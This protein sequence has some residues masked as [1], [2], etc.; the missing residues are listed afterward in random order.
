MRAAVQ[1]SVVMQYVIA[2]GG[3]GMMTDAD[4][5]FVENHILGQFGFL[6]G[7]AQ[8]IYLGD[9]SEA[10]IANRSG[11]YFSSA[12]S[13]FERGRMKAQHND[14]D[15]TR[16]PGD[17]TSECL[18]RDKCFWHYSR[19]EPTILCSWIRTAAESCDTCIVR[20]RCQPVLFTKKTGEHL[21]MECYERAG[22]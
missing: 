2:R 13:S 9:L 7:F 16:H 10:E 6:S 18:A 5:S 11:L 17:G 15:L 12:V 19:T 4:W 14:L 21:N 8:A 1:D 20:A 3:E 22:L